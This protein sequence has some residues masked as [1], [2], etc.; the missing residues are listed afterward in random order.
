MGKG[1]ILIETGLTFLNE[2]MKFKLID[3]LYLFKSNLILKNMGCNNSSVNL[4]RKLRLN[5]RVKVN[6]EKDKLYKIKLK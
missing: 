6:L 4:I 2:L 1:R 5:N 3:D